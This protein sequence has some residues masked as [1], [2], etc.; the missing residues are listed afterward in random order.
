VDSVPDP[1][2]LRKSGSARNRTRT[3]ASVA[4]N[5]D[6]YTTVAVRVFDKFPK[7]HI[8]IL[9]GD[10]KAKVGREDFLN[11]QLETEVYTKL[12]MIMEV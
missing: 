9:L 5:S 3:S 2:L 11:L 10:F 4:R 8:I 6:H 7:Y 1:L 12:V